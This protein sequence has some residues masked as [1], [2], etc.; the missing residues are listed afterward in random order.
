VVHEPL[1]SLDTE[2]RF[3]LTKDVH[4]FVAQLLEGIPAAEIAKILR[5][6]ERSGFH[7]RM[8]R[9]LEAAREYLQQRYKD[10][11]DARFGLL[12]SSR[13]RLLTRFRIYNDYQSTKI[14]RF[15][16]WYGDAQDAPSTTQGLR[17]GVWRAGT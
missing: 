10:Q 4:R 8:T 15:G 17:Y 13:D 9:E 1:L 12:A 14:V 7:L 16:P 5:E 6:L 3:H 2:L 11:P